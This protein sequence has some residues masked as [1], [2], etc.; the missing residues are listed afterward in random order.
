[1]SY[2][3]LQRILR[4]RLPLLGTGKVR[5][6]HAL[7]DGKHCLAVVSDRASIYDIRLGFPIPG[8]GKILNAFNIAARLFLQRVVPNI[9]DDLVAYGADIDRYL[10]PELQCNPELHRRAT[11]I[12]VLKMEDIEC[13][14]R[15]NLTGGGYR[16]YEDDGIVCGH[17]LPSG[18]LEGSPLIPPIFTPTT[19]AKVGHDEPLD[20]RRV[21][22]TH[23]G[24]LEELSLLIFLALQEYSFTRGVIG[25]DTKF[26]FGQRRP[27]NGKHV[28]ADEVWTPDSSRFWGLL[29]YREHFP[30]SLPYPMDKQELRNWGKLVGIDKL[31]PKNSEDV[32]R[33]RELIAPPD[34]TL[35]MQRQTHRVFE[36]LWGMTLADFQRDVMKVYLQ[37]SE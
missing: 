37:A 30:R 21:R 35:K 29:E 18:L 1:M 8:K 14:V 36:M 12:E 9:E 3:E 2:D 10:P 16:A 28:L 13:V 19:K 4:V 6:S 22:E 15:G 33:G 7:P 32:A 27:P 31:D 11:V 20:Y 34:V 25:V 24:E 26:E 5:D 17:T 23:G